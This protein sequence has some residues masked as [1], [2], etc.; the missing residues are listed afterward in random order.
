MAAFVDLIAKLEK[1][2]R[3]NDSTKAPSTT[4]LDEAAGLDSYLEVQ[5]QAPWH[6]CASEGS[7]VEM[8]YRS[9][10]ATYGYWVTKSPRQIQKG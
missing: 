7:G 3:E 1:S 8:S 9:Y 4:D 10:R 5:G 2:V 6:S